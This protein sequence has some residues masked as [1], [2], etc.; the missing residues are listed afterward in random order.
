MSNPLNNLIQS[1]GESQ[2]GHGHRDMGPRS[3]SSVDFCGQNVQNIGT[4]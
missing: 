4:S 2:L 3:P 1:A